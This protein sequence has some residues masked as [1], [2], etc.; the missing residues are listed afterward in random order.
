MSAALAD[1]LAKNYLTKDPELSGG[2]KKKKKKKKTTTE[3]DGKVKTKKSG[4]MIADDDA[5]GWDDDDEDGRAGSDEDAIVVHNS[6]FRKSKTQNWI[7]TSTGKDDHGASEATQVLHQATL[8]R[9][10]RE[11]EDNGGISPPR[12]PSPSSHTNTPQTPSMESGALAGL[13]TGSQVAASLALKRARDLAA[14]HSTNADASLSSGKAQ[15]TIYRD[16]SGRIINI[17][18]LRAEARKKAE[19][20]EAKKAKQLE[21]MKGSVQILEAE[22]RRKEVEEA[23]FQTIGRY[24]DDSALNEELKEVERWN[25][26]AAAFLSSKKKGLSRT[27]K[28]LYQGAAPPNRYGIKPGHRWDGVDRGNGFEKKWFQARGKQAANKELEYAWQMDE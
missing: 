17:A 26:P 10:A 4:I 18:M 11:K 24:K 20:E 19:D 22:K 16:A 14:F 8:E 15:E 21:A 6:T 27:G 9:R 12:S 2:A 7:S 5:M 1:Y 3:K 23:K 25:D 13:Q 28:P